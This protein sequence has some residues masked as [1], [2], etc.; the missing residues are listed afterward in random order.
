MLGPGGGTG[1]R[2]A[3]QGRSCSCG[4]LAVSGRDV[5]GREDAVCRV[6]MD[7]AGDTYVQEVPRVGTLACHLLS[8]AAGGPVPG[9]SWCA[10]DVFSGRPSSLEGHQRRAQILLCA[11]VVVGSL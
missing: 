4:A 11:S 6:G 7:A 10:A 1:T 9:I 3:W 8:S 2:R 5:R